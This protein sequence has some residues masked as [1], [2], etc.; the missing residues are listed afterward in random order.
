M[1][2]GNQLARFC[3]VSANRRLLKRSQF[4]V[5]CITCWVTALL[6]QA[7]ELPP[8]RVQ[9]RIHVK[10]DA[11]C[12]KNLVQLRDIAKI[13]GVLAGT[14]ELIAIGPSPVANDSQSWT[15]AD[16][17]WHL[18]NR[19]ITFDQIEWSGA[20][21]CK[22]KRV[23]ND[24]SNSESR[25][26][27]ASFTEVNGFKPANLTPQIKVTAQR[28][29]E[30][31]I[32]N[33][34]QTES[35]EQLAYKIE[36]KL[37]N[38]V[39][40]ALSLRTNIVGIKGGEFPFIEKQQFEIL[41][42]SGEEKVTA[43]VDAVVTL[44]PTV[45]AA[46]GPLPKGRILAAEDLKEAV[47]PPKSTI[48]FEDCFVDLSS[49]IGKELKKAVS[50]GQPLQRRDLGSPRVVIQNESIQIQVVAGAMIAESSG[51]AL[52]S[53]GHDDVIQ[54]EVYGNKKRLLARV[55][56]PGTVEA[57]AATNTLP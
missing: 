18:E 34:L 29:V 26:K 27:Q 15:K 53:G 5:G 49:V 38:Q 11:E 10:A 7:G 57:I 8:E 1:K 44:P 46:V 3:E 28:N 37:P 51:K 33:Y 17:L 6:C 13:S 50:T 52:Q 43:L 30:Q 42:A 48:L 32:L 31:V 24:L 40:K 4:F 20:Q 9:I 2:D 19:G 12:E 36:F 39:I 23:S 56:G 16:I 35:G 41:Y 14:L 45:W 22:L 47:L 25:V 55:I 54:V 21:A